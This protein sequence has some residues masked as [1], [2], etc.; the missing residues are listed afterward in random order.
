MKTVVKFLLA[1]GIALSIYSGYLTCCKKYG[2]SV[3]FSSGKVESYVGLAA[4][5]KHAG[6]VIF[7]SGGG[8]NSLDDD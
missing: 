8:K 3:L 4:Y 7:L 6:S 5:K 1:L 2:P